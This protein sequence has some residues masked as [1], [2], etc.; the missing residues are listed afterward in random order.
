MLST[1]LK[2]LLLVPLVSCEP[3]LSELFASSLSN[4]LQP[5]HQQES[6]GDARIVG[7]ETS[8]VHYPYQIS[9]QMQSRGGGGGFFFF[10]Q[11]SS[12]W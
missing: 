8:P 10:Q 7:G 3:G 5:Q 4:S 6:K 9:L 2:F 11:P 12:N 1:A